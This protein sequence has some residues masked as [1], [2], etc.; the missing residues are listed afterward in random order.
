[1]LV[2]GEDDLRR[3]RE[4]LEQGWSEETAHNRE[5]W[6][7]S[8]CRSNGQCYGT[9]RTVNRVFEWEIIRIRVPGKGVDHYWNRMPDGRDIDFTSDQFGGDGIHKVE[10]WQGTLVRRGYKTINPRLRRYLKVV[11]GPLRIFKQELESREPGKD[12]GGK[13]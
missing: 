6:R 8:L 12:E 11:E 5:E 3:I 9:A 13:T 10:D 1:M 7:K 2:I 4:I